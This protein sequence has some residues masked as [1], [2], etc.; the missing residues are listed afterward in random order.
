MHGQQRRDRFDFH[1]DARL[2]EKID[3]QTI[4]KF[5]AV[6]LERDKLLSSGAQTAPLQISCQHY[7]IDCLEQ[8]GPEISV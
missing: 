1:D 6:I 7:L 8:P 2:D 5:K 3:A 4:A